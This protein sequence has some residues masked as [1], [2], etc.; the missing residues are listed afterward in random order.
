MSSHRVLITGA[1]GYLGG[2]LLARLK[3]ADLPRYEKLYAL[4]RSDTQAEAV[5][6]YGA[7]AVRLDLQDEDAVRKAIVDNK[8]TIIYF[9]IDA[10]R[11]DSQVYLIKGLAEVKEATGQEVHFL[12]PVMANC[13]VVEEAERRGVRSYIFIPCVVYG[14][15]EGFGNV[16]S[17]QTVAI[18]KAAQAMK[19]VYKV[20]EGR[21]TWPVCHIIDNTNL[22][23]Q[24][25]RM[26][27]KGDDP[28]HGKN[29]Y[30]LAS[31]GSIAWYDLYAAV[32]AAMAERNV[33]T[34][35]SV[36]PASKQIL[37]QMGEALGCP[38]GVVTVQIGGQCTLTAKHG[39]KIGWKPRFAPEHIIE[40]A[41]AEVQLILDNL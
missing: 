15:G 22:Y 7:E 14:K 11:A 12:H 27:L 33:V 32:A 5:G 8:I 9:L 35:D 23:I 19:R 34:D 20:D 21:P 39:K 25:L 6:Q 4:V 37:E 40:D 17:I 41:D 18:I 16:I 3:D 30:F 28:G 31:S 24:I 2:T 26:I 10:M 38:P 13:T 36:I 1:S 29:G